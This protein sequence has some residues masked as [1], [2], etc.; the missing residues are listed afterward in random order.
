VKEEDQ[1][2]TSLLD[3]EGEGGSVQ[4]VPA[5]AMPPPPAPA[6][7]TMTLDPRHRRGSLGP[8]PA[9]APLGDQAS[10]AALHAHL[11]HLLDA[12]Q[13]DE[14]PETEI[15]TEA[16]QRLTPHEDPER[17]PDGVP[18]LVIGLTALFSV[19]FAAVLISMFRSGPT[20]GSV[21][22]VTLAIIAIPVLVSKL[23][24]KAE[25]DRDHVHPSR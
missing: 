10:P 12:D 23:G 11:V 18:H 7:R 16:E 25:R 17:Q 1:P 22:S 3:W 14:P 2:Q 19:L 21:L 24:A 8:P 5:R 9:A 4:P 20:I 6:E 15:V 13:R